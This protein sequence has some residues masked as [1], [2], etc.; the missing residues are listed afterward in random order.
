MNTQITTIWLD[1]LKDLTKV[2]R[3]GNIV[4]PQKTNEW[5]SVQEQVNL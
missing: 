2:C 4:Y 5:P 1:F 3:T